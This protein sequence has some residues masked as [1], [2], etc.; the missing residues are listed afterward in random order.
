MAKAFI[1]SM[2]GCFENF[3]GRERFT[4]VSAGEAEIQYPDG[5]IFNSNSIFE[6]KK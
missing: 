4:L 1:E 6:E 3:K 2:N 5:I